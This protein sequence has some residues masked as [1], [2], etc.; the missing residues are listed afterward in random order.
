MSIINKLQKRI[1]AIT[2][3]TGNYPKEIE[4]SKNEYEDLKIEI[5]KNIS[6][7]I[8][9]LNNDEDLKSFDGVK[10]KIKD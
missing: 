7:K 4:L 3:L 8:K 10:L 6:Y 2:I 9:S 1:K 5:Q